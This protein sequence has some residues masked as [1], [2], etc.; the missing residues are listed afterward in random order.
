M[1][2][3]F[4]F[5]NVDDDY[6]MLSS[7]TWITTSSTFLSGIKITLNSLNRQH[8]FFFSKDAFK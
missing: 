3:V 6:S 2:E 4:V 1:S 7:C 5:D 8:I